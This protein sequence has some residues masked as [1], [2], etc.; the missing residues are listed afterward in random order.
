MRVSCTK[1]TKL[2]IVYR[3]AS[4]SASGQ[5]QDILQRL[6]KEIPTKV[7]VRFHSIIYLITF[8]FLGT[9][10]GFHFIKNIASVLLSLILT[11]QR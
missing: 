1:L 9:T 5:I 6:S 7:T 10:T 2:K 3:N 8:T 4:V 11:I